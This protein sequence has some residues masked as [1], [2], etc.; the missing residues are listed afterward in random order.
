MLDLVDRGPLIRCLH[1]WERVFHF[2]LPRSVVGERVAR[3]VDSLLVEHHEFLGDLA[4]CRANATLCLRKLG[5]AEAVQLG[6]L[7]A[8]ELSESVDLVGGDVELVAPLVRDQQVV[9]LDASDGP[10][11]HAVVL[12]DAVLVVDDEV[13]GLEVFECGRSL[14]ALFAG[15]AVGASAA[16]EVTLGNDCH[17]RIRQCAAA[18]KWRNGDASTLWQR[19]WLDRI[20]RSINDREVET[21]VEEEFVEAC[22]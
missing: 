3:G 14:A 16:S 5:A 17:L 12:A 7:S 18:M 19:R 6:C 8:D 15:R 2:G 4:Y 1:E 11:D 10:L 13:A 20:G 9:T 22:R 21:V